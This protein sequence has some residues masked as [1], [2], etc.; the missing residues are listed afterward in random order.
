[1]GIEHL[2]DLFLF[3]MSLSQEETVA[4]AKNLYRAVSDLRELDPDH[5]SDI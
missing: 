5:R 2:C 4:A 3:S 1:M